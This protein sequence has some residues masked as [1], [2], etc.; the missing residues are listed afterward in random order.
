VNQA[1]LAYFRLPEDLFAFRLG[2]ELSEDTGYFSFGRDTL[3]Y[4]RST[5][6]HRRVETTD[7]LYDVAS[8]VVADGTSIRVPFD[9]DEIVQNLRH[10]RYVSNT[11]DR[12]LR[13][14]NDPRVRKAYYAWF[15][16][17]LPTALRRALQRA[18]LKGCE[19]IQFPRWP[20]DG[21]VEQTLER[22]L[23]LSMAARGIERVPFIWFWPDG[24]NACAIMTHDVDDRLGLDFCSELMDLDDEAGIRASFQ[25]IPE[26]RYLISIALVKEM[27]ARGFEVNVHDLNH[28]GLLFSSREE[29]SRRAE[30]I[31]EYGRRYGARGFRSGQLY[32]NQNWFSDLDFAYDMSVPSVAHLDPQRGGCCSLTPYFIGRILEIP[33]TTIQDY[34]LFHVLK[35]YSTALWQTQGNLITARNGLLSFLVHPEQI[36]EEQA[37]NVYRRLLD[38]LVSLR[39]S[40]G[41]W[42]ALPQ[43][44][45]SWWR[46]RSAMTLIRNGTNWRI[47]G[48]ANERARLAFATL[49]GQRLS[50]EIEKAR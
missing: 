15:R 27:R 8:D 31:N 22:L 26:A 32:R 49:S 46:A 23:A 29:F 43:D 17:V 36:I 24:A 6:G 18:A 9:P 1:L 37:R 16:P 5:V 38:Y 25:I 10:E 19:E 39:D 48:P 7:G 2:G 35:D 47:E 45:D 34:S 4:G 12:R 42:M 33:L 40:R 30:R 3:C 21:T 28:D 14:N 20:V 11:D 44:V 13:P 41:V 50:F